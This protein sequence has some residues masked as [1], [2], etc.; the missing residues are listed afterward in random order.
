MSG[1]YKGFLNIFAWA[2]HDLALGD[3]SDFT[4]HYFSGSGLLQGL[5]Y[6]KYSQLGAFVA[7]I[8][9]DQKSSFFPF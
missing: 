3:L 2:L 8:L 1:P 7:V 5:E 6:S 4:S 9:S